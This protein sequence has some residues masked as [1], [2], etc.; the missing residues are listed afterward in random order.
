[1][2]SLT[3]L[4][5]L[6]TRTELDT[7]VQASSLSQLVKLTNLEHLELEDNLLSGSLP[8]ELAMFAKLE[9]LYVEEDQDNQRF[10]R[11]VCQEIL[12]MKLATLCVS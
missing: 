6:R 11:R 12:D 10:D 9:R 7:Y 3:E 1:M 2:T 4:C 5:I 8:C